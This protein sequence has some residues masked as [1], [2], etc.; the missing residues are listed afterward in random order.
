MVLSKLKRHLTTKYATLAIKNAEH[1]SCL[2]SQTNVPAKFMM[3]TINFSDKA[4]E[5]MS[6][7]VT[8]F[9]CRKA[10]VLH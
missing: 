6:Y 10:Q 4:L 2:K 1:F 8:E 3:K 7:R 5:A 9:M